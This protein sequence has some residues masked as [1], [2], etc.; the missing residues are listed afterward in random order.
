[1]M[2]RPPTTTGLPGLRSRLASSMERP[3][4]GASRFSRDGAVMMMM[5]KTGGGAGGQEGDKNED[6]DVVL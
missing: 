5:G 3:V 4:F 2:K 1:M 6:G